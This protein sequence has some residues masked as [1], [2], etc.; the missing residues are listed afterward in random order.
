MIYPKTSKNAKRDE[1]RR[2]KNKSARLRITPR[3]KKKYKKYTIKKN[4]KSNSV[5]EQTCNVT[6]TRNSAKR[7]SRFQSKAAVKIQ[8]VVRGRLARLFFR[9][10]RLKD[11]RYKLFTRAT[12]THAFKVGGLAQRLETFYNFVSNPHFNSVATSSVFNS[13]V[14]RYNTVLNIF[15]TEN[16]DTEK[17]IYSSRVELDTE[18]LI[19]FYAAKHQIYD[20]EVTMRKCKVRLPPP[21]EVEQARAYSIPL[22]RRQVATD[23]EPYPYFGM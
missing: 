17:R 16:A 10:I 14:R 13:T 18:T 12:L 20:M 8:A 1:R 22:L 23:I 9:K 19:K 2:E 15:K 11:L 21:D 6:P 4:R 3:M 7:V 5:K